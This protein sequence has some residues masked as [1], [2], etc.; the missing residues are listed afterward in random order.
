MLEASICRY[1]QDSRVLELGWF[2]GAMTTTTTT[3]P[4]STLQVELHD[5]EA[6]Q[7]VGFKLSFG[8]VCAIGKALQEQASKRVGRGGDN[9]NELLLRVRTCRTRWSSA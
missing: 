9:N 8:C 2:V 1:A 4:T 5:E 3:E 7:V 6:V